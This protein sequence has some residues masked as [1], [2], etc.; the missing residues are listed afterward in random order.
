[1]LCH[2]YVVQTVHDTYRTFLEILGSIFH[3]LI[4]YK[5]NQFIFM[6]IMWSDKKYEEMNNLEIVPMLKSALHNTIF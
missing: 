5:Y 2:G 6:L 1:M 3:N 4:L